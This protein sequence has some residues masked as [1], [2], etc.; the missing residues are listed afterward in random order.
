M[1]TQSEQLKNLLFPTSMSSATKVNIEEANKLRSQL[2]LSYD[3][4]TEDNSGELVVDGISESEIKEM[5]AENPENAETDPEF[6]RRIL[7]ECGLDPKQVRIVGTIR[8]SKWQQREDGEFLTSY[9]FQIEEKTTSQQLTHYCSPEWV[10]EHFQEIQIEQSQEK[11][12]SG[13][14]FVYHIGDLHVGKSTGT[15]EQGTEHVFKITQLRLKQAV[16]QYKKLSQLEAIEGIAISCIGDLIEGIVSQGGKNTGIKSLDI[17]LTE[18]I[19]VAQQLMSITIREFASL[20]VPLKVMSING[21]HDESQRVPTSTSEGD[22]YCTMIFHSIE[23]AMRDYGGDQFNHVQ[24]VYPADNRGFMTVPVG[25]SEMI[26][27]HGDLWNNGQHNV[28]KWW[29]KQ[30][31]H[32][33][34]PLNGVLLFGHF[35]SPYMDCDGSRTAICCDT[36]EYESSWILNKNG[37]VSKNVGTTFIV[38]D[39]TIS[40]YTQHVGGEDNE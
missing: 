13:Q 31:V 19:R 26:L 10:K 25:S 38:A 18:Q 11:H 34:V 6:Q 7:I 33:Q 16:E 15:P 3:Y 2:K 35:H 12:K 40:Y 14:W 28:L 23:Q 20:G 30:A 4:K 37:S 21:N 29:D 8:V 27:T 17:S 5:G 9:R 22:G 32:Q 39:N 1:S 36:Y 24:F